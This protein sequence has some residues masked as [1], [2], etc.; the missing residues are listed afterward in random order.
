MLFM[1][2][3]FA[4]FDVIDA[5]GANRYMRDLMGYCRHCAIRLSAPHMT[6]INLFVVIYTIVVFYKPLKHGIFPFGGRAQV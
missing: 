1:V 5:V 2:I 6:F 4:Q 3:C